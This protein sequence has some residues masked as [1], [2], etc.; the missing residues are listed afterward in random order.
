MAAETKDTYTRLKDK[1]RPLHNGD[2]F[3][4]RH[5]KMDVAKRDKQFM[6]F[7]ALRGFDAAIDIAKD[8]STLAERHEL[9]EG[10]IAVL[11]QKLR[12]LAALFQSNK[13]RRRTTTVS[14]TH[15]VSKETK[16]DGRTLGE[17]VTTSGDLNALSPVGQYLVINDRKI[18][19]KNIETI[20]C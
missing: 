19:F 2:I 4:F 7:D 5:P 16:E 6:P 11:D 15:F 1:H 17:Y 18:E 14:V 10:E 3:S 13:R 12:F 20:R 9:D 8:A